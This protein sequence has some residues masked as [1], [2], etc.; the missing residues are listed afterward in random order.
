MDDSNN[1]N[2]FLDHIAIAVAN[3]DSAQKIFED[4]GLK[5]CPSREIVISQKVVTVF[6][7]IENKTHL[8]LVSPL[9]ND[10]PIQKF[11]CKKGEG[12]HHLCFRVP[13]ITDTCNL[14]KEKRYQIIY[15][16][17]IMGANNCLV[18]FIHPNSTGGILIELSE[19][20]VSSSSLSS[21]LSTETI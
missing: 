4:I 16:E 20:Q 15:S 9:N 19:V 1:E 18:N 2:I 10:G 13:N 21:Q 11:I 14:L 17:P 6:A 8:E 12:I 3:L 7:Q 5:F